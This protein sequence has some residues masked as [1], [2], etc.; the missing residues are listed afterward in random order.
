MIMFP[1]LG[2]I[3]VPSMFLKCNKMFTIQMKIEILGGINV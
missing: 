1:F 2:P 3:A